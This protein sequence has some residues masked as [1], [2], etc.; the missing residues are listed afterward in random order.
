MTTVWMV[1][2]GQHSRLIEEFSKGYVAIGWHEMGDMG[3]ITSIDQMREEYVRRYPDGKPGGVANAIAMAFK[4]TKVIAKGDQ[5]ITYLISAV[6]Q[7]SLR[8]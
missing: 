7:P 8:I 6:S 2:A 3:S 1:R 5:V 4:F